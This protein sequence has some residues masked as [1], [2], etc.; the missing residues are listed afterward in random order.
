MANKTHKS[1]GGLLRADRWPEAALISF[2]TGP[3][4]PNAAENAP[5]AISQNAAIS[6][7]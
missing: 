2:A 6:W 7:D 5:R 1:E 3:G 4:E